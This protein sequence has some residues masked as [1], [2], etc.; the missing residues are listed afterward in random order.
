MPKIF[1]GPLLL[2]WCKTCNLPILERNKCDVCG[3]LTERVAI[4]PPGD[5]RPA[6]KGD[7]N[8]IWET[9]NREYGEGVGERLIP[10]NKLVVLNKIGADESS[11]E[12]IIDGKII[13]LLVFDPIKLEWFFRPK[14]EGARR[15]IE[16]KQQ[17]YV[18]VSND[19][20]EYIKKGA[21]VLPPGILDFD[22]KICIGDYVS[23]INEDNKVI[24]IGIAKYNGA[25]I[26]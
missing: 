7:L 8:I 18:K 15:L 26:N 17:K 24:G 6:L 21:N 9:I 4:S 16:L 20:A 2:K 11:D 19:A 23:I 25:D 14:L 13:G 12:I 22:S 10:E 5:I 1:L 3:N